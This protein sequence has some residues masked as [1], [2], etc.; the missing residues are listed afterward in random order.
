M[1]NRASKKILK[2]ETNREVEEKSIT[3]EAVDELRKLLRSSDPKL[4]IR[5]ISLILR[6]T[7]KLK[8]KASDDIDYIGIV[9]EILKENE[10]KS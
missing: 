9:E 2:A 1:G 8:R 3:E 7:E 5:A 10:Q 6:H 4:K